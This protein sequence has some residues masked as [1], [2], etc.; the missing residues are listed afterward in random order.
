MTLLYSIRT[1]QNFWEAQITLVRL[2][3]FWNPRFFA[4]WRG[5]ARQL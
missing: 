5:C 1:R 2:H 4:R 3:T